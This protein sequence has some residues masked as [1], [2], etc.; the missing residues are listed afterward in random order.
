[1][2][3][4]DDLKLHECDTC[5]VKWLCADLPPEWKVSEDYGLLCAECLKAV[6][7][8]LTSRRDSRK[9]DNILKS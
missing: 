6:E 1:M 9:R 2:A 4:I 5:A 7:S 8:T 3:I